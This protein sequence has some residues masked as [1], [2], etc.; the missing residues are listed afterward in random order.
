[1]CAGGKVSSFLYCVEVI[2]PFVWVVAGIV[3]GWFPYWSALALVAM[4]L[5]LGNARQAMKYNKEGMKALV[6]VFFS[7]L[8][9]QGFWMS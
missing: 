8:C 4:V 6:G 9:K 5:A 1:M 2:F 7:L 3:L